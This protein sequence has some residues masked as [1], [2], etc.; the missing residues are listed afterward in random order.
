MQDDVV[1]IMLYFLIFTVNPM[2]QVNGASDSTE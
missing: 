2:L 1:G